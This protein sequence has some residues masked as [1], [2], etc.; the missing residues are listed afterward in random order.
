MARWLRVIAMLSTIAALG[1]AAVALLS[2]W[3]APDQY[4]AWKICG[5]NGLY[6][7]PPPPRTDT[8]GFV[9]GPTLP[10]VAFWLIFVGILLIFAATIVMSRLPR[11]VNRVTSLS[12]V[13]AL[14]LLVL[15]ARL[16]IIIA[17]S[18]RWIS[19][20][21]GCEIGAGQYRYSLPS[22]WLFLWCL[23]PCCVA[24]LTQFFGSRLRGPHPL[25]PSPTGEGEPDESVVTR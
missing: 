25:P 24:V 20:G 4:C 18:D 19:C 16:P 17:W 3:M 12:A 2:V 15:D 11:T 5:Y 10:F 8:I 14:A 9:V 22:E 7:P 6:P 13:G 21:P 23:I 1:G